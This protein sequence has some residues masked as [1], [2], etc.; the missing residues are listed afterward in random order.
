MQ[1]TNLSGPNATVVTAP[2]TEGQPTTA[3]PVPGASSVPPVQAN[4]LTPEPTPAATAKPAEP[5]VKRATPTKQGYPNINVVPAREDGQTLT[6]AAR[7]KVIR[8]LTKL[9]DQQKES[10]AKSSKA[11]S[12]LADQAQNHG[13]EAL[14]QI[15]KCSQEGASAN[16]ECGV[17]APE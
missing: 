1:T 10:G 9:R 12:D 14:E 5:P 11:T 15:E 13:A 16:P 7:N 3:N 17:S 8:E 6:P 2:A 4:A